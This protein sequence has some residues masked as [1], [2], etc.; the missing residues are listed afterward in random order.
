MDTILERKNNKKKYLTAAVLAALILGY[1]AYA[2]I[3]KKR[4]YN[5]AQSEITIKTVESDFFED[6]MVLQA[7]VEPMNSILVNIV[8]GGS[9]QEIF[10]S[11]GDNL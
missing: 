4:A 6:F 5:V 1:A 3:T 7:R 8:E 2:M 9:V 10:V 11:N